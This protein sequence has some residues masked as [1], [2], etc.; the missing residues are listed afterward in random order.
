MNALAMPLAMLP[1]RYGLGF[2]GG[3][4]L[5]EPYFD[6]QFYWL[7]DD[8]WAREG[9]RRSAWYKWEG[10]LGAQLASYE[11][12]APVAG[13]V[14]ELFG[15]RWRVFRQPERRFLTVRT[16]WALEDGVK[17][18]GQVRQLEAELKAWGHGR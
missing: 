16:S 5:A 10:G 11:L 6:G 17:E 1:G 7:H 2:G 18:F 4:G 13:E 12:R 15:H 9:K 14:R 3:F 8:I